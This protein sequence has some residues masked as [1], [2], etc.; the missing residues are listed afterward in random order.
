[1]IIHQS[2]YGDVDNAWGLIRTS[3][4]DNTIAKNLTLKTDLT[5]QTIGISWQPAIRGFCIGDQFLIIKTFEDNSAGVRRGR[6]FSH[7]LMIQK[8]EIIKMTSLKPLFELLLPDVKK[9]IELSQINLD[10]PK[11]NIVNQ[12]KYDKILENRL[13][14]MINGYISIED[15]KNKILWL[16]QDYFDIAVDELWKRLTYTEKESFHFGITFNND[17]KENIGINLYTVPDS[18]SNKFIRTDYFIIRKNDTHL[19]S[20]LLEKVIWGE[21]NAINRVRNFE[22]KIESTE[23]SRSDIK[24]LEKGLDTFEKVDSTIDLKK[25]NTLSHLVAKYSPEP[26][27]GKVFK[28]KLLNIIIQRIQNV[29]FSDIMILRLFKVGSY[30]NSQNLLSE[31]LKKYIKVTFFSAKT[32]IS[33]VKVFFE[34]LKTDSTQW[35]DVI[36]FD[37]LKYFGDNI[38]K[39]K[40]KIVYKWLNEI[41]SAL[42]KLASFL[43]TNDKT[44]NLLITWLPSKMNDHLWGGL[45]KLAI[46]RCWF[47]LY[48]NLLDQKHPMEQSLSELL[49][50]DTREDSYNAIDVILANKN[51]KSIIDYTI[52]NGDNRLIKICGR[53]C[54]EQPSLLSNINHFDDNWQK[55][56]VEAILC[57]NIITDGFNN[58]QEEVYALLEGL[59]NGRIVSE[60]LI[61][62]ISESVYGNLIDFPNCPNLWNIIKDPAR[63]NFLSKTSSALLEELSKNSSFVIPSDPVMEMHV[64]GR[65]ITDYLYYN[66]TNLKSVIPVFEHFTHLTDQNLKDYLNNYPNDIDAINAK[67]LGVLIYKRNFKKSA[68]VIYK[69]ASKHN[70]WRFALTECQHL[71]DFIK[72]GILAFSGVLDKVNIPTDQWWDAAQETIIELYSNANNLTTIWKK[73][74]GKESDLKMSGSTADAWSDALHKLRYSKLKKIT[75]DSLLNEINKQYGGNDNF[76]IIYRLRSAYIKTN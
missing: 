49:K 14:K 24:I 31:F 46:D 74:G 17:N 71:F 27:N 69:K 8:Q 5:E 19:P 76:K 50:V 38:D 60:L 48:A 58:P 70:N 29:P 68:D 44:E 18:V 66:R 59:I 9:D 34:N 67:K 3:Q 55:I 75:M 56:W 65:G 51:K 41:P 25:L 30:N 16:G 47:I 10:I 23:L 63:N 20:N 4:K 21:Q 6:K 62:K 37:E 28:E 39:K 42:P 1:M 61:E 36:I 43:N 22:K 11:E 53:F 57:G 15:Y 12:N 40:V 7:V 13:L 52:V 26:A 32:Q 64:A 73:A 35:W 33:T 2:I 54:N 72:R 45:A